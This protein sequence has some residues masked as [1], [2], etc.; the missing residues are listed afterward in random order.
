M[1]RPEE[2]RDRLRRSPFQPLAF[3]DS[4]NRRYEIRHPEM[5]MVGER[6]VTIGIPSSKEGI[7][8]QTVNVALV[9]IVRWEDL[10]VAGSPTSDGNEPIPPVA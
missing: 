9:H 4:L 3:Y 6:Y 1:W 5:A 10:P 2:L 7:F 8:S